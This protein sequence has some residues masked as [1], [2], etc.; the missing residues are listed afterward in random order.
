M[1]FEIVGEESV[2]TT[3]TRVFNYIG[4]EIVDPLSGR[5]L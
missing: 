5:F 1:Y 4:Q 2:I 3:L